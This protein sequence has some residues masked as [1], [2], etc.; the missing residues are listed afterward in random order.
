MSFRL[1]YATMFD[2]P[3]A[4]H[5]RFEAAHATV[6]AGLGASHPLFIDGRDVD[7]D[8]VASRPSPVDTTLDLGRFALAGPVH[9]GQAMAAAHLPAC[10]QW[11]DYGYFA[12]AGGYNA[13][14]R[15]LPLGPAAPTAYYAANDLMAVGILRALREQQIRVPEQ[16]SVIGTNDSAE[17]THVVPALT[18]LRVPYAE[19]AI[20]A[21]TMLIDAILADEELPPRQQVIDC[22]LI[23]RQSSG[24]APFALGHP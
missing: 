6:R 22:E 4:M 11:I 12:E 3:E 18:T 13:V 8:G 17:A 24:P 2:P 19:M 23:E 14:A 20:A 16:V 1:T 15:M 5:Q 21:A 10:E 7:G 9:V